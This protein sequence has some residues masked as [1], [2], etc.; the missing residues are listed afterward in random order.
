MIKITKQLFSLLTPNQR[1]RFYLL[2]FLVILMAFMEIIGVASII[3]FMALVGDMTQL[4]QE[5][6]YAQVYQAS[7]IESESE[8]VVILGIGVVVTL[9]VSGT[10]SLFT[11]WRLCMFGTQLGTELSTRLYTHYIKQNWLFHASVN[12]AKLTKKIVNE[13]NRVSGGIILPLMQMNARVVFTLF[14]VISI[15]IYDPRVAIVGLSVFAIVYLILFKIVKRSLERNGKAISQIFSK[16][17]RLNNEGFGGIKDL[18]L[19]GRGDNFIESFNQT[20]KSL[21]HSQGTINALAQVPR[22]FIELVAFGSMMTITLY[23]ISSY[24][25]NLGMIL[26][27]LSLYTLAAFKLLPAIQNI[28]ANVAAIKGNI[29]AFESIHDDLIWSSKPKALIQESKQSFLRVKHQISLNNITFTYPDKT[30]ST[31]QKINMSILAN[32]VIGIVGPSGSGKS[33]LINILLGLIEPQQGEMKIDN[34]ILNYKN[35]RSWQNTIGFVAQ[36]IFLS[37]R[38]IAENVAFGISKNEINLDKVKKALELSHL[39]ELLQSLEKG[40]YTPVGERGVKLSGGQSQ[41]IGIARALYHEAEILVFDE[42]TSSLDGIS[43]RRVMDAIHEFGGQKTIIMIA[44][45]IKT[46]QNCNKI[47]Y[48]DKGRV[49]DQGTYKELIERNDDFKNMA[50]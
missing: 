6:F 47:F 41:R 45:R 23:L 33:T 44:H 4:Q 18:L 46:V 26:P 42:A 40:I 34:T 38:S 15:F 35:R 50:I 14:M 3:P 29:A 24:D 43:E 9:F 25:G 27:T 12:S 5:T 49:V 28:Y 16:R 20:S 19:L 22:Y 36:D 30:K 21:A 31:L 10:I 8:F 17:Y 39:T 13:T 11:T 32:S 2:Q 48:I 1:K 37:D 7:G